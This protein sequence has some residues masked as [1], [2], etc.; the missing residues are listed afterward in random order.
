MEI[1]DVE[2]H[3]PEI[4]RAIADILG[5]NFLGF[6]LVGS[7]VMGAWNPQTSD[8][9]FLVVVQSPLN[10]VED[11]ALQNFHAA[12]ARTELGGRLEGEYLDLA[13]LRLKNFALR[14]GT[15]L[16]GI[17]QPGYPCQLSADNVLCLIQYGRCIL[18]RPVAQLGAEVTVQEFK[19][20]AYEM[21]LEDQEEFATTTDFAARAYLL[22]DI[23]RCIYTLRTGQLPTKA[24]ALVFNRD[25]LSKD[26]YEK[27]L[28]HQQGKLAQ[29]PIP[30]DEVQQLLAYA[31]SLAR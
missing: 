11:T 27:L 26:L 3:L 23:L 20:A 4:A 8:L 16:D 18:G 28:S 21:L 2:T 14:I 12:L 25:L 17:Y 1:H 29:F 6:Y 24:G 5:D 10:A 9:D 7:F 15:V 13:N 30:E 22:I 19:Q 31:R